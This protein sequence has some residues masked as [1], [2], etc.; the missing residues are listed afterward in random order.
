MID[1]ASGNVARTRVAAIEMIGKSNG[2]RTLSAIATK[3]N[4]NDR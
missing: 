3:V 2:L 4:P 1:S